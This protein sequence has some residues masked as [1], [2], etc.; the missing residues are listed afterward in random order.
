MYY[1]LQK[2]LSHN[3]LFSFVLGN[4][5]AGKSYSAKDFAI[6]NFLKDGS[7]FVYVRRYKTEFAKLK[8]FFDDIREAYPGHVF[9]VKGRDFYIDETY[10][11]TSIA[12]STSQK[13]KSS[14]F[15]FVTTIIFDEFIIKEGVHHYIRDE[16]ELFLDLYETIARTRNVRV[17]FIGNTITKINPYF[18]YFGLYPRP[19]SKFTKKGETVV[20]LFKNEEFVEM[21]KDSRF[22]KLIAGTEYA[23]FAIENE[24][25]NDDEKFI[26]SLTGKAIYWLCIVFMGQEYGV[27]FHPEKGYIYINHKVESGGYRFCFTTDDHTPNYILLASI[28]STSMIKK[29]RNAYEIGYVRFDTLRTKKDFYEFMGLL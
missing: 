16:V 26:E 9:E 18:A 15:P 11:G 2:L 19:G 25:L 22:G 12:L 17:L 6:R 10:A 28:K 4:R 13:D 23:G 1:S 24:F 29:M 20:E 21:K 5:G 14:T 3:K 7:Q 8:T 27:W